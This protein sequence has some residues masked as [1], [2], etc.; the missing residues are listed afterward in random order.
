[1]K[2]R[3]MKHTAAACTLSL[4]TLLLGAGPAAADSPNAGPAG[5]NVTAPKSA[6]TRVGPLDNTT[7]GNLKALVPDG[8]SHEE[9]FSGDTT[10]WYGWL[11]EPG[12]TYS[13]DAYDPY[14]DYFQ[15]AVGSLAVF[16]T[17]GTSSPPETNVL[18]SSTAADL[19]P[20]F[21]ASS[22]YNGSRCI[23][24]TFVPAAG[25]AQD[26]RTIAIRVNSFTNACFAIRVRESTIYGRW[27]T[28]GYDFHVELQNTTENSV[29]AEV[30]LYQNSGT[31]YN[32]TNPNFY[33]LTVPAY[34]A[35]KIVVPAGTMVG[36]DRRGTLRVHACPGT[37][38]LN[39]GSL[40]VSTY[41]FNPVS[42]QY[43]YFFPWTANNGNSANSG[44]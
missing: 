21:G 36:S 14:S 28:N 37:V 20:G 24:R 10:K 18:C 31:T 9:C 19:A 32:S 11:A 16:Q 5:Q 39:P 17:D 7:V 13:V 1:M 15:G 44:W 34:G 22:G 3:D 30:D 29:C 23:V 38:N 4:A 35:D 8:T 27:T 12:K 40:H 42:G 33:Y 26:K 41:A 6:S 25:N 43:L 2:S